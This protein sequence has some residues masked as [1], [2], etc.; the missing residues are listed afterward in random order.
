MDNNKKPVDY[1]S[2][3]ADPL[4]RAKKFEKKKWSNQKWR[5]WVEEDD[6]DSDDAEQKVE[7]V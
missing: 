5:D 7:E 1:T 3:K 4:K 2:E 6:D